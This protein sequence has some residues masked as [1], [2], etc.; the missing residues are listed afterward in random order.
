VLL[1][2]LVVADRSV[3]R[4]TTAKV[5]KGEITPGDPALQDYVRD[6]PA[7]R[8]V[9]ARQQAM[10]PAEKCDFECAAA[11]VASYLGCAGVCAKTLN[12]TAAVF[13]VED[14][15]PV[16]V[17]AATE[18]CLKKNPICL[19]GSAESRAADFSRA[20]AAPQCTSGDMDI[21]KKSGR[22]GFDK[23]MNDCAKKCFGSKGC[24]SQCVQQTAAYSKGCSDCFGDLGQCT[25][26]H[27]TLQCIK[28]ETDAC[29]TCTKKNCVQP[30]KDCSGFEDVPDASF[31]AQGSVGATALAA[32]DQK[33]EEGSGRK[34]F[35]GVESSSNTCALK[36][37]LGAIG[38]YWGCALGCVYEHSATQCITAVCPAVV[39]A[40]DTGCLKS[41]KRGTEATGAAVQFV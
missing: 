21:W 33:L 40:T 5:L 10:P 39:A 31:D 38:V 23:Y 3:D 20:D 11:G 16:V 35:A 17:A 30:F 36:C 9:W 13:C 41:C 7:V 15:C 25:R 4:E 22:D 28:G 37:T 18:A 29:K 27:C 6:L 8:D 14:G 1:S 12:Y 32:F 19:N 24:V 34:P 2:A 26:D